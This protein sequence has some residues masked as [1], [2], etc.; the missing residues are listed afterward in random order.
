M[1]QFA[2][3]WHWVLC[4]QCIVWRHGPKQWVR[5]ETILEIQADVMRVQKW[6]NSAATLRGS[7]CCWVRERSRRWRRGLGPE[8]EGRCCPKSFPC[9]NLSNLHTEPMKEV[10]PRFLFSVGTLRLREVTWVIQLVSIRARIW[11]GGWFQ[12]QCSQ[13][14]PPAVLHDRGLAGHKVMMGKNAKRPRIMLSSGQN[15]LGSK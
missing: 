1:H 2:N 4:R 6:S 13:L 11:P 3:R 5:E 7:L 14:L 12:S 9:I 15:Y 10:V 8:L